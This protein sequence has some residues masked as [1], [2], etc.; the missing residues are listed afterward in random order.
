MMFDRVSQQLGITNGQI[1]REQFMAYSQQRAQERASG[2]GGPPAPPGSAPGTLPTPGGP[3]SGRSGAAAD[4]NAEAWNR[5]VEDR[6]RRY[7][8]NGDGLLNFDEMPESL[9]AERDKWDTNH[10]G[11]IDLNEF[12]AYYQA[13]TQQ[14]MA[15]SGAASPFGALPVDQYGLPITVPVEEEE[16]KKPVVYR[17]GK[18]PKELPSWF[19][20]LDTD[21][22]GQIGLYEWKLS[23]R[24]I[25]E[26]QSMDRNNDG[27]LTIEEVLRFTANNK[28]NSE[29]VAAANGEN[30]NGPGDGNNASM[31]PSRGPRSFGG[32]GPPSMGRGGPPRMPGGGG[33]PRGGSTGGG[34]RGPPGS[35]R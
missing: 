23:G 25:E 29:E 33:P 32:N 24:S 26:F 31:M 16:D 6:F 2:M 10:D 11:F 1:T 3:A 19:K 4:P 21:N 7:D 20:Q 30:S 17:S 8:H 34:R 13:R 35:N 22:D 15:E 9:R 12:K 27:F 18:L 14:R 28:A 5:W